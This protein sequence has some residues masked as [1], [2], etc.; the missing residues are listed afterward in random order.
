MSEAED[1]ILKVSSDYA[2]CKGLD[3]VAFAKFLELMMM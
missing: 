2:N 1:S 3:L